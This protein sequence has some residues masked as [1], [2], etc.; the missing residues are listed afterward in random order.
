MKKIKTL[1]SL[2]LVLS[3][4]LASA[5]TEISRDIYTIYGTRI[6]ATSTDISPFVEIAYSTKTDEFGVSFLDKSGKRTSMNYGYIDL[7]SCS[8]KTI[9]PIVG[10]EVAD[11]YNILNKCD[12]PVFM[13]VWDSG[14][15]YGIYKIDTFGGLYDSK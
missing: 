8:V 15:E 13:S 1:L 6:S 11:I 5:W 7:R 10:T 9:T 3:C 2:V 4:S 14:N 12:R